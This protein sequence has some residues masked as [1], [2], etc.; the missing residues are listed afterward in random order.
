MKTTSLDRME[1]DPRSYAIDLT[2]PIVH[3]SGE[4]EWGFTRTWYS[5]FSFKQLLWLSIA[6]RY[7]FCFFRI[8]DVDHFL[9]LYWIC[10][11]I[12][13]VS[14]LCFGFLT[15]RLM[16]SYLPDWRSSPPSV[17][18]GEVLTT[19]PPGKSLAFS[20]DIFSNSQNPR[21]FTGITQRA[22]WGTNCWA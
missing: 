12:V 8:F 22:C 19:G 5:F 4:S 6:F 16:G 1:P 7:F 14:F 17:L 11:S 9:S 21:V 13:S 3:W 15:D 10:Y 20:F 2:S 18:E